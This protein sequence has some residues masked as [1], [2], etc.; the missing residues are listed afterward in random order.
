ML[1]DLEEQDALMGPAFRPYGYRENHA[2]VAAFCEEQFAQ[3]LIQERLDPDVLFEDFE[4]L[5]GRR[6][7]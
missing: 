5:V 3:G 2:M 6:A 1:A 7:V 4:R